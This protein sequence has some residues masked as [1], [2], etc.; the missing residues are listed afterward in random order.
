M[1]FLILLT[2]MILGSI[3]GFETRPSSFPLSCAQ[4]L[5]AILVLLVIFHHLPSFVNSF[6]RFI[7]TACGRYAVTLFFFMSGYGLFLQYEKNKVTFL[8]SFFSRRYIKLLLPYV[9]VWFLYAFCCDNYSLECFIDNIIT[10]ENVIPFAYFVEE[11]AIFYLIFYLSFKYFTYPRGFIL[12]LVLTI[13]MMG[14]F[15]FL[16]WNTHWWTSSLGFPTGILVCRY[17]THLCRLNTTT[18]LLVVIASILAYI[19]RTQEDL[20]PRSVFFTLVF[21]PLCCLIISMCFPLLKWTQSRYSALNYIGNISYEMYLIQGVIL[22]MNLPWNREL[23][24][25][26]VVTLTIIT[27]TALHFIVQKQRKQINKLFL[28]KN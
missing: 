18:C 26:A 20:I 16:G 1:I 25:L 11:L 13:I 22:T 24:S 12:L 17:R 9:T 4:V 23:N 7:Q 8:N 5:R 2:V 21:S 14:S 10:G 27:G 19:S 3:R 28:E 15:L 6:I